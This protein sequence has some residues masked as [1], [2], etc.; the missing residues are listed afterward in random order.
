MKHGNILQIGEVSQ[1]GVD[2]RVEED[3]TVADVIGYPEDEG[4]DRTNSD[5]PR[6]SNS[7]PVIF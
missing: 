4:S 3:S 2:R 5:Q 6:S 7:Y 1:T